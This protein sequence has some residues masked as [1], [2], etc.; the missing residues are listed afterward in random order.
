MVGAGN[1]EAQTSLEH[2]VGPSHSHPYL[3]STSPAVFQYFCD[4]KPKEGQRQAAPGQYLSWVSI[5]RGKSCSLPNEVVS[6]SQDQP[7][8][9]LPWVWIWH[10]A[11]GTRT[12]QEG[13]SGG[14]VLAVE[15]AV[16]AAANCLLGQLW[17]VGMAA[18]HCVTH[19]EQGRVSCQGVRDHPSGGCCRRG[20]SPHGNF[21]SPPSQMLSCISGCCGC[22]VPQIAVAQHREIAPETGKNKNRE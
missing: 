22:H 6:F 8:H 3:F 11:C 2:Q 18:G 1:P 4:L 17:D 19:P 21:F 20:L 10:R 9:S 7:Q 13:G 14:A 12:Q 15:P 5:S 16:K